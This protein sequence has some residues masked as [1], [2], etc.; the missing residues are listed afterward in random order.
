VVPRD[1]LDAAVKRKIPLLYL[2]ELNPSHAAHS[3]VSTLSE[4]HQWLSDTIQIF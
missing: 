2:S 3:L 1:S 4:Q